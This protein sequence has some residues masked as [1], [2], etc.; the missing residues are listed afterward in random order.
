MKTSVLSVF[1]NYKTT[2]CGLSAAV[3]N[4][5]IAQHVGNLQLEQ[6]LLS[7]ALLFGG[8]AAADAARK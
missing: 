1:S 6:T 2:I 3:L 5:L 7:A 8:A 4:Y